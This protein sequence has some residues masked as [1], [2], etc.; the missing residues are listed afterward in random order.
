MAT[1]EKKKSCLYFGCDFSV[2]YSFGKI[3]KTVATGCSCNVVVVLLWCGVPGLWT[4]LDTCGCHRTY[5]MYLAC[6]ALPSF[7]LCVATA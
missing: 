2:W 6:F 4:M 3:V 1:D 7:I 5:C